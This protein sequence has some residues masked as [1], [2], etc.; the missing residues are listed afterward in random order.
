MSTPDTDMVRV[1]GFYRNRNG[2]TEWVP[3]GERKRPK[4]RWTQESIIAAFHNWVDL[5]G[6]VP[7]IVDWNPSLCRN[8]GNPARQ[9]RYLN[10]VWPNS[11]TVV[12]HFGGWV[13]AVH[14]AGLEP[15]IS[16]PRCGVR[17]ASPA[18]LSRRNLARVQSIHNVEARVGPA[19]LA[20]KVRAVGEAE[21]ANEPD[22]LTDALLDL[23]AVA[24]AWADRAD[25]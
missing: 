7:G 15:R 20:V 5:Y 12:R 17:L 14:A 22:L 18:K 10:G 9:A 8:R 1:E 2:K 6:E 3:P 21:R 25:R 16:G 11:S 23:A 4:S 13:A 24:V 19:E